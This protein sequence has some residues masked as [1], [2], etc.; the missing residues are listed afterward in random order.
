MEVAAKRLSDVDALEALLLG[1]FKDLEDEI[2][3]RDLAWKEREEV[4]RTR[5]RDWHTRLA[6]WQA[7]LGRKSQQLEA[8]KLQLLE[9]IQS[10][11]AKITRADNPK[12]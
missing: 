10:Y 8:L 3:Q 2:H 1:R 6:E 12:D 4:L 9:T 5:D 7:E 11:K